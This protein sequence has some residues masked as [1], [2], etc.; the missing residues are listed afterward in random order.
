MENTNALLTGA[1]DQLM[2]HQLTGCT[3]AAYQAARLLDALAE[4]AEVDVITQSLCGQMCDR[5][6]GAHHV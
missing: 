1:L 2:R 6:Q 3:R 5:L 4:S